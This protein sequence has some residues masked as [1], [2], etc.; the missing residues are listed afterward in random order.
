MERG[1]GALLDEWSR[2]LKKEVQLADKATAA[3]PLII[4]P[5]S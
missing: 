3:I 1:W 4:A 2:K 5:S